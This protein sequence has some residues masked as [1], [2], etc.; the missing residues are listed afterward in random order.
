[1][2]QQSEP[3]WT[4]CYTLPGAEH[5]ARAGI[6]NVGF[7]TFLPTFVRKGMFRGRLTETVNP[8]ISRYVFV[9]IDHAN[10]E[11]IGEIHQELI[12]GVSHIVGQVRD[13]EMH[14]LVMAHAS[15]TFNVVT[16]RDNSGRFARYGKRRPRPRPGKRLRLRNHTDTTNHH[17][18]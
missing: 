9:A 14:R 18:A 13:A 8:L 12:D 4:A 1:M 5:K 10:E 6:E 3:Y 16:H 17:A 2:S 7:G 15:G 11:Q